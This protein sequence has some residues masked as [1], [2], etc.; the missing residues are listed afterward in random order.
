MGNKW[1]GM[2]ELNDGVLEPVVGLWE[3]SDGSMSTKWWG[4]W[5]P[6]IGLC[7][8]NNGSIGAKWLGK[9]GGVY[10]PIVRVSE[11]KEGGRVSN[12]GNIGP[13]G[14]K[15]GTKLWGLRTRWWRH[16]NQWWRYGNQWWK[17]IGQMIWVKELIYEE[18]FFLIKNI[19]F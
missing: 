11:P 17:Y 9:G 1:W 15:I 13:S 7:E 4:V 5:E 19:Y 10:E 18:F 12:D 3:L 2:W 6:M 16:G 14:G 8:T